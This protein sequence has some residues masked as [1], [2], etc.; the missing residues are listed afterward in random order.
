M[1]VTNKHHT[2][3]SM[4]T[5]RLSA[6]MRQYV[7]DARYNDNQD[8]IG[9]AELAEK[10]G[11]NKRTLKSYIA[12]DRAPVDARFFDLARALPAHFIN[13]MLALCGYGNATPLRLSCAQIVNANHAQY[14]LALRMQKL[15]AAMLDGHIDHVE[16]R[17]L[18]E[19]FER[20]VTMMNLFV[21]GLKQA[22]DKGRGDEL[23][24][25]ITSKD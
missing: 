10:T 8:K 9:I 21:W 20:L 6:L 16:R 18:I 19:E 4:V 14:E 12:G 7:A 23:A 24:L 1:A 3:H 15:S 13:Q 17:E 2:D 25:T 22:D 5:Q 11:I